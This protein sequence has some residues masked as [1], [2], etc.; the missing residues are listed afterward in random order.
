MEKLLI[1]GGSGFLGSRLKTAYQD[2]Y[3]VCTPTHSELDITNKDSVAAFFITERPDKVIHCAGMADVVSCEK[4]P[5]ESA[6]VNVVGSLNMASVAAQYKAK[7]IIC[8]SDQVYC[9]NRGN[10]AHNEDEVVFPY[11]Q[12]GKQKRSAEKEC[13]RVNPDSIILRL[14]WMYEPDNLADLTRM[15]Y[16]RNLCNKIQNN[17]KIRYSTRDRRG[18]TDV[19]EVVANMEKAFELPGGIYNFGS[20]NKFNT[21]DLTKN[22]IS[23]LGISLRYIEEDTAAFS[24]NSRNLLM[25]QE[26]I[27]KYGIVF[28]NSYDALYDCLRGKIK[29]PV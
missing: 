8:S 11:N 10:I 29:V 20:P 23:S 21:Y 2:K 14:S 18:I 16:P 22:L 15:D 13:Q 1:T 24:N 7:I 3:E 27:N 19:N 26:K 5:D 12:Y 6:V 17:E 28:R 9:G 4:K 25:S